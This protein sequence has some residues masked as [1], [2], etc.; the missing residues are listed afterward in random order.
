MI[1]PL[2]KLRQVYLIFQQLYIVSFA[3]LVSDRSNCW[4]RHLKGS[5]E[6]FAKLFQI[7]F[8]S[9]LR[10]V[11]KTIKNNSL[12]RIGVTLFNSKMK[13]KCCESSQTIIIIAVITTQGQDLQ[14][15]WIC[16]W[17]I[18]ISAPIDI[19]GSLKINV[20]WSAIDL[21]SHTYIN[22]GMKLFPNDF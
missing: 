6:V 9:E 4:K 20:N 12:H 13:L 17:N 8:G 18:G 3:A 14:E 1:L 7:L 2:R 16:D 21:E 11:C 19:A 5:F 15:E 22:L 10:T